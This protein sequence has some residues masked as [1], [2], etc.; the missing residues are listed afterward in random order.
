MTEKEDTQD[1]E[2]NEESCDI[3]NL[4]HKNEKYICEHGHIRYS[5]SKGVQEVCTICGSTKLTKIIEK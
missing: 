2:C 3:C 5:N 4:K 1:C